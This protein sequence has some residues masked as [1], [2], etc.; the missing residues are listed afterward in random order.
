MRKNFLSGHD[1]KMNE[2]LWK[3]IQRGYR[4]RFFFEERI[5]LFLFKGEFLKENFLRVSFRFAQILGAPYFCVP[6]RFLISIGKMVLS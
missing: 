2:V 3:K 1:M 4:K 5:S 6:V